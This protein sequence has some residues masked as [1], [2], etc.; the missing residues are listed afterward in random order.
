LAREKNGKYVEGGYCF[1]AN[2]LQPALLSAVLPGRNQSHRQGMKKLKKYGGTIC[3]IDDHEF[4]NI[5]LDGDRPIYHV[6]IDGRN[7]EIIRDSFLK[8]AK[9]LFAVGAKDVWFGDVNDT[10]ITSPDQIEKAVA[11]IEI[12]PARLVLAS[13][14]PA[15]GARM[16]KDPKNS[17]VGFDHRVHGTDN[18]YVS[19]PSVFPTAPSVDPSLSIMAFSCV[20]AEQIKSALQ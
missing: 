19:D 14:H 3:W 13:P 6:P 18:F 17:V 16:G 9:L 1:V 10:Q 8:Q 4:G 7:G 15:G 2:Q 12:S 5:K 11:Q 20:A